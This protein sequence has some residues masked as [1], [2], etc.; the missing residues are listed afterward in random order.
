MPLSIKDITFVFC[1]FLG[2][3]KQDINRLIRVMGIEEI[4]SNGTV[5]GIFNISV[6]VG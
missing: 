3:F 1:L 5:F 6:I 2:L 4:S